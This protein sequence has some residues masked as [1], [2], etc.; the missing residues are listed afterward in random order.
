MGIVH[1][2]IPEEETRWLCDALGLE[3]AVETGTYTTPPPLP[4]AYRHWPTVKDIIQ[5]VPDAYQV[6]IH[7]D[8]IYILPNRLDI[9]EFMRD[10]GEKVWVEYSRQKANTPQNRAKTLLN[11][12]FRSIKRVQLD[13]KEA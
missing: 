12:V 4:Q 5:A 9:I 2:G 6:F 10:M 7:E 8:V 11:W 3:T 1:F 13:P